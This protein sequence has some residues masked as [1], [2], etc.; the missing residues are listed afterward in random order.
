MNKKIILLSFMFLS[1]LLLSL[2]VTSAYSI[3]T[4]TLSDSISYHE[5]VKGKDR[6]FSLTRS[7]DV[8][9][10][11]PQGYWDWHYRPKVVYPNPSTHIISDNLALESFRTFQRDSD[12]EY[13]LR[14]ER[15]R[16]RYRY[17]YSYG[18]NYGYHSGSSWWGF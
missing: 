17:G 12:N 9:R 5:N 8:S 13:K 14:L 7:N 11:T 4:F 15:E 1:A 18:Y 16:N 2:S 10:L 6:G 3:G